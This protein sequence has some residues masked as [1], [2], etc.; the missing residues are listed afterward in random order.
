MHESSLIAG[1]LRIVV[2]EAQKHHVSRIV[3]VRVGLGLL[4]CVEE[5]TL[6]ACFELLAENTVAEGA[7]LQCEREPLPCVCRQCQQNF[8][9]T[10][11]H[12]ICP[13]CQSSHVD[14]TGGH[15]CRLLS[16][17]AAKSHEDI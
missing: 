8:I 17:E 16:I 15:G 12:F 10:K 3:Q 4:A 5:Q 13:S 14:F 2:E 6:T 7:V 1:L 11:R 9:L